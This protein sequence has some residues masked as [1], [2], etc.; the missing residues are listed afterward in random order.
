[1]DVGKILNIWTNEYN[2][3]QKWKLLAWYERMIGIREGKFLAPVNI[4]LDLNQGTSK[5]KA[6][7]KFNCNFCMSNFVEYEEKPSQVP[8]ELLLGLPKFFAEWGV[9]SLCIAGHH[10]DPALYNQDVT[11]KFLIQCKGYGIQVGFVTNGA[12]LTKDLM[13]VLVHTCEWTG[14]S[15]NAGT[16]ETHRL[17]TKT[18][19]WDKI[20]ENIQIMYDYQFRYNLKHTIGYKYII[21]DDNY[22]EIDNG[23]RLASSIGVRHFQLR[24]GE[25]SLERSRK[26]DTKVVEHQ[27]KKALSYQRRDFEVFGLREKFTAEF[28]KITPNRCIASPLG[29]TWMAD[30]TVV[31]CPD[32][33]WTA[34]RFNLGNFIE[35]GPDI[36]RERWGSKRHMEMIRAINEDIHNCIRCTAF[37]W[38]HIYENVV[39]EDKLNITLI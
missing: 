1:M 28:T 5:V 15:I 8:Y 25:L 14:F 34:N 4:A 36:I 13:K 3:F 19:T 23:V 27:M 33:R 35:E 29:S 6:C 7:G 20:I 32:R 38:H 16:K 21:T 18:D 9:K 24:P 22:M 11:S 10:S 17:I 26:I 37:S 2:P 30:G 12:Y 31:I 39:M